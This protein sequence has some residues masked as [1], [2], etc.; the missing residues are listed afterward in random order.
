MSNP[1]SFF[2]LILSQFYHPYSNKYKQS[3]DHQYISDCK[4]SLS[5]ICLG[6]FY[7][8]VYVEREKMNKWAQIHK[9]ELCDAQ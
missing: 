1:N 7:L 5:A 8:C 2:V 6:S 4:A 3:R 9:T